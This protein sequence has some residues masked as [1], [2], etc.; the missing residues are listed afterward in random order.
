MQKE[1]WM[2]EKIFKNCAPFINC[3]SEINNTEI[4][5]ARDINIVIPMH[6]MIEY[7]DNYSKPT[8]SLWHYYK[9]KPNN[10]LADSESSKSKVKIIGNTPDKCNTKDGEIIT[11]LKYLSNFW[12]TF[13]YC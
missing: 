8:G 9:D 4:D 10:N 2:K 1:K 13:E 5:N 12:R 11:P 7:S 6:K 3:K